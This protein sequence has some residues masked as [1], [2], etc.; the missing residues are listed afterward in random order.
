MKVGEAAFALRVVRRRAGDAAVV[1][2]RRLAP[3]GRERMGRVAAIGPLAFAAGGPLLRQA[4]RATEGAEA[5]L[6]DGAFHPLDPDWGAR[7]ACFGL[8]AAGLRDPD[9]LHRAAAS[10]Q[11]SDGVEAAWWLGLMVNGH[12]GR[13]TRALRILTEAVE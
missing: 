13:A 1:Y 9:R 8:I 3:D 2:Q 5:A 12:G 10:L 4:V 7:V 6:S 11:R